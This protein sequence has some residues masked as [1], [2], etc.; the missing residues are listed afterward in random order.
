MTDFIDYLEN[1]REEH[2]LDFIARGLKNSLDETELK[3]LI[4]HLSV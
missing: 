4:E 3:I 1:I 2:T